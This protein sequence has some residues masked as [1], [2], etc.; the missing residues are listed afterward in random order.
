[1]QELI[2]DRKVR[3]SVK[4]GPGN[5]SYTMDEDHESASF[6]YRLVCVELYLD[7]LVLR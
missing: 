4:H 1:M 7:L 5:V 2:G 3:G 6:V